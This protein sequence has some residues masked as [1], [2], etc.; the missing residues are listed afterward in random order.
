MSPPLQ[1]LPPEYL[2]QHI[3]DALATDPRARELGVDVRV[4]GT[5]VVLTG[6]VPTPDLRT[7]IGVVAG[8]VVEREAGTAH[9]VVNELSVTAGGAGPVE[10]L[11]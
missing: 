7:A 4:V 5:S 8:E 11:S 9:D 10:E 2:V 3:Q 6:S 1:P